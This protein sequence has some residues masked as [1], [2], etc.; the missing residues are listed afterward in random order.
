MSIHLPTEIYAALLGALVG[1]L[2]TYWFAL[3]IINKQAL[4]SK[5][6]SNYEFLRMQGTQLRSSFSPEL[7]YLRSVEGFADNQEKV[8]ERLWDAFKI[9]ATELEK[10]RFFV[11]NEHLSAYSDACEQYE[12]TLYPGY[13][14]DIGEKTPSEFFIDHINL[15]LSFTDPNEN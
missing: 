4:H 10:F 8:R 7:A 13:E 14:I 1:A 6:L 9:H 15:V 2:I 3:K 12:Q 11:K 5:E